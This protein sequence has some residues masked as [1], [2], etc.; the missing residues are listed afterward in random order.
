VLFGLAFVLPWWWGFSSSAC[1]W[2]NDGYPIYRVFE[3]LLPA[4]MSGFLFFSIGIVV[5]IVPGLVTGGLALYEVGKE[6][7][8]PAGQND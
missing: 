1:G 6:S 2:L 4:T 5:A 7:S 8:P 3:G